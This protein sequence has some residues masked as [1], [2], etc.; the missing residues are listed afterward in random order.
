[1]QLFQILSVATSIYLVLLI[2]RIVTSWLRGPSLGGPN[3][4]LRKVTDPYL[5][6]FA[7][8]VPARA[9]AG[10]DISSLVGLG[11]LIV[12]RTI[13]QAGAAGVDLT[14]R[15]I[16]WVTALVLVGMS[17]WIAVIFLL[18]T[19]AQWWMARYVGGTGSPVARVTE[20]ISRPPLTLVQRYL[21]LGPGK[22]EDTY[23]LV[24]S[25][26]CGL[27]TVALWLLYGALFAVGPGP[28]AS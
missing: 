14:L 23:L 7:S 12:A 19:L 22:D 8:I 1:M 11:V 27:A 4:L 18:A 17:R 16:A 3:D 2:L 6:F 13:F 5:R 26:A 21:R 25:V 9:A 10:L 28:A 20:A 24:A 15:L